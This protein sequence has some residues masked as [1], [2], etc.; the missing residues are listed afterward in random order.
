[1]RST[2]KLLYL[3]FDLL[4]AVVVITVALAVASNLTNA[5]AK[6][7]TVYT[8]KDGNFQHIDFI[9]YYMAGT[10]ARADQATRYKAYDAAVQLS[11]YN[12]VIAPASI[13]RPIFFNYPPYSFPLMTAFSWLPLRQAYL[14]WDGLSL[15]FALIALLMAGRA[16][17]S[18]PLASLAAIALLFF[19]SF[20]GSDCLIDGQTT[21]WAIGLIAF[22]YLGLKRHN[23]LLAGVST[24]LLAIKPHFFLFMV[25]PLLVS[26]LA[27]RKRPLIVAAL[28]GAALL[29]TG[30]LALGLDQTI[31]Y[32]KFAVAGEN[33][34]LCPMTFP[35][36]MVCLRG[37][38]SLFL[39]NHLSMQIGFVGFVV[40]LVA[41]FLLF[42]KAKRLE[43]SYALA[44]PILL[45]FSPHMHV[46]DCALL[47][48][49]ACLL[50]PSIRPSAIV[51]QSD[52]APF[53]IFC[54]L[55]LSYV[56]SSWLIMVLAPEFG[57]AFLPPDVQAKLNVNDLAC[58]LLSFPVFLAFDLLVLA[59]GL[60]AWAKAERPGTATAEITPALIEE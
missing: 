8:T 33:T 55:L 16:A 38:A 2:R 46:Y 15:L 13:H 51:S 41:V 40:G 7:A 53:K 19:L 47:A 5:I 24:A 29:L 1:L 12:K 30:V 32:P 45:S 21:F 17:G 18:L 37:P 49:P 20:P 39:S 23:D 4:C 57:K 31:N 56:V 52:S 28:T 14:A 60:L 43:W 6:N 9:S 3:L 44:I 27:G 35:E 26:A 58:A 22:S 42:K 50:L 11:V 36:R 25:I 59:L 10:L 54:L 34:D 48:V